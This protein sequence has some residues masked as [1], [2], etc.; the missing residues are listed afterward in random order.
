M[1]RLLK[2]LRINDVSSVDRG[3]GEGVRVMLLKR[4]DS[5]VDEY[6]KRTFSDD[7]RDE[8][9]SSGKALPDGSFPI[10]NKGDLGNAIRAIGRAKDPAKAK[11]HIKARAKTLGATDMLPDSWDKRGDNVI[12]MTG[13]LRKEGAVDFDTAN[14]TQ[15]SAEAANDLM[16]ELNEAICALSC[17]V[18]SI[19]CD[20]EVSDK[21]A[22]VADS[23]EQFKTHLSGLTAE[24]T[25]KAMTTPTAEQITKQITDAVAAAMTSATAEIAKLKE[26]NTFLK[27]DAAEQDFCKAMSAEDKAKFAA[28]AKADRG[29]DMEDA[30][31]AA[32]IQLPPEIAK[33]LADADADRV[34][35]KALQEKDEIATFQKKATDLGLPADKGELIRKAWKGDAAAQG[36]M[37]ALIKQTNAALEAARKAGGVFK[38]FGTLQG[39]AGKAYDQ[40]IAKARDYQKTEAGKGMTESQ[41]F[42]KVYELP[43]NKDLAAQEKDER[44]AQRAA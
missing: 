36:E 30:K 19:M 6:L 3:A 32:V 16:C 31:K 5:D 33:R 27:L 34:V 18:N 1:P 26:E 42:A 28:K 12:D 8:L 21:A 25:E 4:L 35:L 37:E 15:E 2:D 24:S 9:A 43:E 20:E 10:E 13:L 38:E 29:K 44:S 22:A 23:F 14:Q 17:S 41:A 40:L 7:K 11:A 39:V